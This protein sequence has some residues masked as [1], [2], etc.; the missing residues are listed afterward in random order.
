MK[1][2]LES[3][4]QFYDFGIYLTPIVHPYDRARDTATG[5]IL[6]NFCN[7]MF[8][9][10]DHIPFPVPDNVRMM[11]ILSSEEFRDCYSVRKRVDRL[12][13]TTPSTE[14]HFVSTDE[15]MEDFGSVQKLGLFP[16]SQLRGALEETSFEWYSDFLKTVIAPALDGGRISD[17]TDP[18]TC[19]A[20]GRVIAYILYSGDPE[21]ELFHLIAYSPQK[22]SWKEILFFNSDHVRSGSMISLCSRR[23]RI[24]SVLISS[25]S[26]GRELELQMDSLVM[27]KY[28]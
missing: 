6:K 19:R 25:W 14:A 27:E 1:I 9:Y 11:A 4:Q 20:I 28:P 21:H 3:T 24:C 2:G 8:E 18:L 10:I 13:D 26:S 5:D 12:F 7:S 23:S 17:R 15:T 16:T 22:T